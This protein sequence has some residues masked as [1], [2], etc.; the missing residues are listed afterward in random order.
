MR[1]ELEPHIGAGKIKLG[2]TRDETR[3]ILGKSENS[4]DKSL[5]DNGDVSIPVIA[6][7]L[8]LIHI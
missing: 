2:M 6:K 1:F 3:K 4:S 8:S 5:I 7:D